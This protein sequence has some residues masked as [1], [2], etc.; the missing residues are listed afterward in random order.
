LRGGG[1]SEIGFKFQFSERDEEI[2]IKKFNLEGIE[3]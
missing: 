1:A 2:L 3:G